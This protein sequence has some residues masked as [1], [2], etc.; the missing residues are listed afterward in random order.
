VMPDAIELQ[1]ASIVQSDCIYPGPCPPRTLWG[2]SPDPWILSG[3]PL[4]VTAHSLTSTETLAQCRERAAA[5]C[6]CDWFTELMSRPQVPTC[7]L[8][9]G[10]GE[11]RK[12]E[13]MMQGNTWQYRVTLC[14]P[15]WDP[16]Y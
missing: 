4:W 11:G 1:G 2:R 5:W 15:T 8:L 10:P 3:L 12:P 9:P 6:D 16:G 13:K 14:Q 7:S